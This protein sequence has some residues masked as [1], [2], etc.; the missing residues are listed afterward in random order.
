MRQQPP[1]R[2]SNGSAVP[3]PCWDVCSITTKAD[4]CSTVS[5][6]RD[7]SSAFSYTGNQWQNFYPS[8]QRLADVRRG[9]HERHHLAGYVEAERLVGYARQSESGQGLS[10]RTVA[11]QCLFRRIRQA[12]RHLSA[13]SCPTCPI[14]VSAGEKV[15]A[16]GSGCRSQLLPQPPALRGCILQENH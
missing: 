16:W 6:R 5:F 8:A 4:T 10:C 13:T 2:A 7:G 15:E 12:V 14:P 1:T 11:H 3:Y 9:V